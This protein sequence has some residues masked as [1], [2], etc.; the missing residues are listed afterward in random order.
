VRRI[1]CEISLVDIV[2]HSMRKSRYRKARVS[3][4]SGHSMIDMS[5]KTGCMMSR[6]SDRMKTHGTVESDARYKEEIDSVH[7]TE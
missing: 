5:S 3:V 6:S 4:V 1:T 7:S 2:T